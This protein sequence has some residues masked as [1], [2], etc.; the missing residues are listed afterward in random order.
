MNQSGVKSTEFYTLF[1]IGFLFSRYTITLI[2]CYLWTRK[3]GQSA[4]S[5]TTQAV[6]IHDI[7]NFHTFLAGC[8]SRKETSPCSLSNLQDSSWIGEEDTSLSYSRKNVFLIFVFIFFHFLYIPQG[9]ICRAK[10]ILPSPDHVLCSSCLWCLDQE[11]R[12]LFLCLC[13]PYVILA[14]RLGLWKEKIPWK[15]NTMA[16]C[17][18]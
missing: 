12:V 9:V 15:T 14:P 2:R 6:T 10:I 1:L 13:F 5:A 3:L 18:G 7:R 4:L 16:G 17:R 11:K 8:S